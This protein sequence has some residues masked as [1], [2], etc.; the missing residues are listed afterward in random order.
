[1]LF[2]QMK[3][4]DGVIL[5]AILVPTVVSIYLFILGK[6]GAKG[7][8]QEYTTKSGI[9]HTAKKERKEYIV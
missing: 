1:M 7:L 2:I 9:K 5:V 6:A 3:L 8:T 4:V